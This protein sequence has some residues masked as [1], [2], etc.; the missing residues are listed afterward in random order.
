MIFE[1][2]FFF[3]LLLYLVVGG[4]RE[5]EGMSLV[6]Y[7]YFVNIVVKYILLLVGFLIWV[8]VCCD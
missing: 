8:F 4:I 7:R 2:F 1:Y 3:G 6:L 5:V